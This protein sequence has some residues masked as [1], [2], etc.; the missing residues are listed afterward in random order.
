MILLCEA[1][2][3]AYELS[4]PVQLFE[5]FLGLLSVFRRHG[6]LPY[7]RKLRQGEREGEREGGRKRKRGKEKEGEREKEKGEDKG[8]Q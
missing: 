7:R 5:R 4:L 3:T 1:S 6:V 8:V 2:W